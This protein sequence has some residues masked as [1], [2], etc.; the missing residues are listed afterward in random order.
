MAIRDGDP[1]L[2]KVMA[3]F[4][5]KDNE[6]NNRRTT[7]LAA[8]AVH[9][10]KL[11]ET[12]E[13]RHTMYSQ[14][15][16]GNYVELLVRVT[17]ASQQS[18]SMMG[19]RAAHPPL[20][21]LQRSALWDVKEMAQDAQDVSSSMRSSMNKYAM[22]DPPGGASFRLGETRC[23]FVAPLPTPLLFLCL[24]LGTPAYSLFH[25]PPSPR[26]RHSPVGSS[27][28]LKTSPH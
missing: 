23:D 28:G 16:M 22:K 17:N 4:R 11:L 1:D 27:V 20:V 13:Q 9:L 21:R 7:T 18:S 14:F 25:V 5:M 3:C 15:D 8:S 26:H 12:G 6:T 10:G 19:E 2:L 24:C